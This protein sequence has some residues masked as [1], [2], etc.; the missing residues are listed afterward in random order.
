[1]LLLG[2]QLQ[3]SLGLVPGNQAAPGALYSQGW[4]QA[5]LTS[6]LPLGS[7]GGRP[8]LLEPPGSPGPQCG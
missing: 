2:L 7:R 6:T 1:M 8:R 5:D 3:V 4:P